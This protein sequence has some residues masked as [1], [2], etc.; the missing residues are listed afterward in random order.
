VRFGPASA[1]ARALLGVVKTLT[2]FN[3][4][5]SANSISF[6]LG[7]TAAYRFSGTFTATQMTGT[8]EITE[9]PESGRFTVTRQ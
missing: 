2:L 1:R 4:K 9:F 8:F 6:E 7:A 5:V 3:G